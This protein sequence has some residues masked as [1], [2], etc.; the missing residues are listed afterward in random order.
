MEHQGENGQAKRAVFEALGT[1]YPWMK[2][3]HQR[4][5]RDYATRIFDYCGPKSP[6]E[7]RARSFAK[8]LNVLR[9]AGER[10][11]MSV[12]S[13]SKI[14]SDFKA[15]PVLQ[16]G[17]HLL[18]LIEPEAYYS[19]VFSLI[20]LSA[21]G[22]AS[23]VSYAVSTVNLVERPR[24][25]PGWLSV[26]GQAVN[27]FGLS[28][29]ELLPYSLLSGRG[30]YEFKL[31]STEA[32]N[33]HALAQLRELLPSAQFERP[34]HALKCANRALWPELFGTGFSFL[35]IDDEDIADLVTDHLTEWGSWLRSRLLENKSFAY[36]ILS[37]IDKLTT[38]AWGGWLTRGTDFFW[39]YENG[40][41]VP[42]RLVAGDLVHP[43]TGLNVAAFTASD[44]IP[45]LV[46]RSL[47]PNLLLMFLVLA[48]L[49]GVRV[50]GGS[51]H[52]IYYPLMRYVVCRALAATG[53]DG[54]L[55][56]ALAT[57]DM[58]GAW[59]HR[60]IDCGG[61]PIERLGNLLTGKVDEVVGSFG[62][63]PLFDACGGMNGFVSDPQ[64]CELRR[65]LQAGTTAPT[66]A[67]WFFS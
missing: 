62:D 6:C 48:V 7:L 27:V 61:P 36:N 52:P 43:T 30:A 58:P 12:E 50:L 55:V 44:I 38:G 4:P 64:W 51:H 57:D 28:R 53:L 63:I 42:L 11:G 13:V 2:E 49:P 65:S 59:G 37:E 17:P 18:L 1:L 32:S 25:G 60:I 9:R 31:K 29:S 39:L 23:Y 14:C 21:H 46:D 35:Q 33:G 66:D 34:S 19:H 15:R 10:N 26:D 3:Y 8:V 16:T 41:R 54:D 56:D 67:E 40:K 47:I 5:L 24:K 22:Q 45:R 20:G